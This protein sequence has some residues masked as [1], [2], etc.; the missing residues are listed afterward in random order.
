[1]RLALRRPF[2]SNIRT[3]PLYRGRCITQMGYLCGY[4]GVACGQLTSEN[5]VMAKFSTAPP[6]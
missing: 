4:L 6:Q 3:I 5:S 2:I 1:M